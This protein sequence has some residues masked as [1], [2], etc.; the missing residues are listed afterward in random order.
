MDRRQ[1]RTHRRHP[2]DLRSGILHLGRIQTLELDERTPRRSGFP[3]G[4]LRSSCGRTFD[5]NEVRSDTRYDIR[6]SY[7]YGFRTPTLQELYFSFHNDNH[8][9]DGNPDL[10]AEY[11]NNVTGS[12]TY[13]ILHNAR[14]RLTTTLSGFYN[15]FK[16]KISLAQNVDIPNYN[17]Y[18]NIGRYKTLGGAL[19]T[20]LAWG[21]LRVNVNA[22]LIGRYNKYASDDKSLPQ[23]RYSPEVSTTISYHIAK[24][25][26]DIS[27]F[28][29]YTGQR[30]EYYYHE[31]TTPDNKK[32]SEIYL[33]GLP[34]YHYG[35]ITVTQKLTSFLSL[36]VGVKN[37]FNLTDI[38][39]IVESANDTPSVSYLGCGRSYFI[40]LNLMLNGKFK[41]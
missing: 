12:F 25:G 37:L 39:T 4:R 24:S 40:G 38:R 19:E 7:A 5:F 2:H 16:D 1:G 34:S 21:G 27:F 10:K 33:R 28:Y 23:F 26:T 20:S 9:I 8:D 15:V 17:T 22:S 14:I 6:L 36:N 11:S 41:K 18:Y 35:D 3:D 31:Y 13:R 29:K 30:K 32:E